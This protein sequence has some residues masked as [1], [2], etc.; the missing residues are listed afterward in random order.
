M[1]AFASIL[2]ICTLL[3]GASPAAQGP[4][5]RRGF[6][7][8]PGFGPGIDILSVEPLELSPPLPGV[9]FSADTQTEMTQQFADGNRVEQRTTG[10][11]ARNAAGKIRKE[12]TLVGFGAST[13]EVRI[14]T[15]TSPADGVQ[16]RLDENTRTAWRLQLPPRPPDR[17]GSVGRPAPPAR[18]GMKIEPLASIQYEGVK[19]EGT[20]T[21]MVI[22]AG[23]IGNE[24]PIEVVT[25]RWYAPEL[26]IVVHSRRVDPRFGEVTYRLV[27]ISRAEP[28]SHLFDVPADFTVREQRPFWPRPQGQD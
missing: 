3:S 22:P 28:A 21:V 17:G 1:R 12:L 4:P 11:I 9:P 8:G 6:P 2:A 24:R 20:R 13:G 15:V 7:P 25:E 16:F 5:G 19:A 26:Q 23:G 27:N 14:V 10:Y 18:P